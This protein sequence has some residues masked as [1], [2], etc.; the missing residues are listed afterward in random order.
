MDNLTVHRLHTTAEE[1]DDVLPAP[2]IQRPLLPKPSPQSSWSSK[3]A[4]ELFN[5]SYALPDVEAIAG[6]SSI[7]VKFR[8]SRKW[9]VKPRFSPSHSK[10]SDS[11][12]SGESR[13]R[14]SVPHCRLSNCNLR[15]HQDYLET[16]NAQK[17]STC[18]STSDSTAILPSADNEV[19]ESSN[20]QPELRVNKRR[21]PSPFAQCWGVD[22]LPQLALEAS[23]SHESGFRE[24]F[25][26]YFTDVFDKMTPVFFPPPVDSM[27]KSRLIGSAML[28]PLYC[29][30][31][32]LHC[33]SIQ[34]LQGIGHFEDRKTRLL[35]GKATQAVR[36]KLMN[37]QKSTISDVLLAICAM[38][39]FESSTP[40]LQSLSSHRAA[41]KALAEIQGGINHVGRIRAY[42]VQADHVLAIFMHTSPLFERTPSLHPEPPQTRS[43]KYGTAFYGTNVADELDQIVLDFCIDTCCLIEPF[44]QI[45]GEPHDASLN[46]AKRRYEFYFSKSRLGGRFPSL[47]EQYKTELSISRCVLLATKIMEY[48]VLNNHL[49]T[50]TIPF[51]STELRGILEAQDLTAVWGH[52]QCQS[53]MLM[54]I[55]FVLA[56]SPAIWTGHD[57]VVAAIYHQLRSRYSGTDWDDGWKDVEWHNVKR[58]VWSEVNLS[59]GFDK[60]CT[61]L[62][63]RRAVDSK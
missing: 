57:W 5:S 34:L 45:H 15:T 48:P 47:H 2:T 63:A 18:A 28:N 7:K 14:C 43:G 54:W 13:R 50:P 12:S 19:S 56:V 30:T 51:L 37:I 16:L 33:K 44:Q 22:G 20:V 29:I 27:L 24:L 39:A 3:V 61:E 36:A 9:A 46:T 4:E 1:R 31:L 25:H 23:T 35:Y 32:L 41:L 59:S 17:K 38:V 60:V 10:S 52:R 11:K 49:P 62:D 55:Y 26:Y 6:A 53:D 42:L 40:N 8:P 21:A 58:F